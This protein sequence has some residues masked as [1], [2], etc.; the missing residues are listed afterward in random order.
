MASLLL[1]E[2]IQHS[3]HAV[4]QPVYI[5]ALDAQSAFD[6]CLRQILIC[7]LYRAGV[8]DAAL[9]LINNRLANRA[10]VYEW[11]RELLGPAPDVTGFEQGGSTP[12]IIINYTTTYNL[13]LHSYQSLEW[14]LDLL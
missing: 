12:L 11:N 8:T 13:R 9:P 7:E 1:T 3:L 5:L 10:T 2:V 4:N 14:I 6:R